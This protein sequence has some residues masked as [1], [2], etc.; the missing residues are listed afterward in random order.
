MNATFTKLYAA[1]KQAKAYA[2]WLTAIRTAA[3]WDEFCAYPQIN[4]WAIWFVRNVK[5][6]APLYA[7]YQAKRAPLDADYEAKRASLNA[8]Y[9]AKRASLNANYKAKRAP[10]YEDY[11]AKRALLCAD[12]AAKCA[13]LDAELVANI[14]A[15]YEI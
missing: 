9:E 11:D 6:C 4:A 5:E 2:P 12:Y 10:L 14:R 13:S 1:A 15:R 7:D 3:N 8:D